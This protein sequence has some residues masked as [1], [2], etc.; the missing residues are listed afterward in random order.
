[1]II[2]K[3]ISESSQRLFSEAES[4]VDLFYFVWAVIRGSPVSPISDNSQ[5]PLSLSPPT[6]INLTKTSDNFTQI[7]SFA[8]IHSV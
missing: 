3:R 4:S 8:E 2:E 6:P 5:Y 7:D 1:M